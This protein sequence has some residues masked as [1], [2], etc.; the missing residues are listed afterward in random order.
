MQIWDPRE[1][2]VQQKYKL[3]NF[4]EAT[5]L[6]TQS[7]SFFQAPVPTDRRHPTSPYMSQLVFAPDLVIQPTEAAEQTVA[8]PFPGTF[9]H[10]GFA[11]FRA[12]LFL[13]KS[14]LGLNHW[15]G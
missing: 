4:S 13:R 5:Q 14:C 6:L 7:C 11:E 2:R 9:L 8:P 15:A 1:D 12:P 10:W 3:Y